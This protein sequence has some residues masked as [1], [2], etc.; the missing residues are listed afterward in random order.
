MY[1]IGQL[2]NINSYKR[3]LIKH[4]SFF[5][6]VYVFKIILLSCRNDTVEKFTLRSNELRL[7][8]NNLNA[9]SSVLPYLLPFC[10]Q[11]TID[12]LSRFFSYR[13]YYF[14]V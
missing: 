2:K 9:S 12:L 4:F 11:Q 10:C 1:S 5:N 3:G 13:H 14:S 7:N 8:L 6:L